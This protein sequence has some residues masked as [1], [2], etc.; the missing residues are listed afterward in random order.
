MRPLLRILLHGSLAAA[1]PRLPS[2]STGTASTA[3]AAQLSRGFRTARRVEGEDARADT[4]KG[5]GDAR[6]A[7]WDEKSASSLGSSSG[8][9]CPGAKAS[10]VTTAVG[11]AADGRLLGVGPSPSR[12]FAWEHRAPPEVSPKSIV[13]ETRWEVS[14]R[15]SFDGGGEGEKGDG[16]DAAR[17]S[18]G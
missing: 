14:R 17:R 7:V 9:S 4:E 2:H 13:V 5:C 8:G 18:R 6:G 16:G 1:R 3:S 12:G 15:G 11:G 10:T